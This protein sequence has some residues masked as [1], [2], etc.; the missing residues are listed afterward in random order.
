MVQGGNGNAGNTV[1]VGTLLKQLVVSDTGL[2]DE[3]RI[4]CASNAHVSVLE[5]KYS[6]KKTE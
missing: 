3:M 2:R 4:K 5:I 1:R 6:V